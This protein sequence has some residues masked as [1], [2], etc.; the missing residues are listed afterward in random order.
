MEYDQWRPMDIWNL[1][2][3]AKSN[4]KHWWLFTYLRIDNTDGEGSRGKDV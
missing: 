1:E 4:Y 2:K 3:G